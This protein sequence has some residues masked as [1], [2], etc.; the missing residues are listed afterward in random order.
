MNFKETCD[1]IL[2]L[3][4]EENKCDFLK[5]H[6]IYKNELNNID[7]IINNK[8]DLDENIDINE[9]FNLLSEFDEKINNND[10]T[11]HEFKRI[12][13]LNELIEKKIQI[14]KLNVTK[15]VD[16]N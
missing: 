7:Q 10:I 2:D 3:S 1:K 8:S 13:D 4:K 15:I 6:N 14:E 5:N 16:N 12:K 9:L 11:I